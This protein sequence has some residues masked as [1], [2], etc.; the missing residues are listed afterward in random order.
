VIVFV[1][2]G[3]A[4]FFFLL[5]IVFLLATHGGLVDSSQMVVTSPSKKVHSVRPKLLAPQRAARREKRE[6]L[7]ADVG[8]AREE[9][10][11]KAKDIA[12]SNGRSVGMVQPSH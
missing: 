5:V 4:S 10:L 1:D 6:K 2:C 7:A 8:Q 3:D 9:L 12:D 11:N